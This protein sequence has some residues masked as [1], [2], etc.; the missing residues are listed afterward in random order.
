MCP[1][2]AITW[3]MEDQ[4]ISLRQIEYFTAV[5]EEMNFTKAAAK[6]HVSQTAVTKQ[7]QLLEAELGCQL[8][9]R[10]NKQITLTDAGKFFIP[11]AKRAL[12]GVSLAEKN[13]KAFLNGEAGELRVGFLSDLDHYITTTLLTRFSKMYPRIDLAITTGSSRELLQRLESGAADCIIADRPGP[14]SGCEYLV[15]RHYPLV[16]AYRKGCPDAPLLFAARYDD[17][18]VTESELNGIF[19][20]VAS[21]IGSMITRDSVCRSQYAGYLDFSDILENNILPAYL[22]FRRSNIHDRILMYFVNTFRG[23]EFKTI[24]D[25]PYG[26]ITKVTTSSAV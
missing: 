22:I 19:I 5:T 8:F 12:N 6:L 2:A 13:M 15:I 24:P 11:E 14:Q 17:E 16:R 18:K 1:A 25:G 7:V 23:D 9:S 26:G 21:G 4:N 20:K 3:A 10:V